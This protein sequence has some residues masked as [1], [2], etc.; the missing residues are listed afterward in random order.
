MP[1]W[2]S[3][4]DVSFENSKKPRVGSQSTILTDHQ[5]SQIMGMPQLLE[6]RD[7]RKAYLL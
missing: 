7:H 6:A 4:P 3:S 5:K 2:F 1:G